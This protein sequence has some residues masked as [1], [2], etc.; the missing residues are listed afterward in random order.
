MTR[1]FVAILVEGRGLRCWALADGTRR[2]PPE[3]EPDAAFRAYGCY[4]R[5]FHAVLSGADLYM[6]VLSQCVRRR[7][8]QSQRVFVAS[9]F[10][11]ALSA[12]RTV[13]YANALV[14]DTRLSAYMTTG[15]AASV[16]ATA[17][18][19]ELFYSDIST[20]NCK[21]L[22]TAREILIRT[23]EISSLCLYLN[24]TLLFH[25]RHHLQIWSS[26]RDGRTVNC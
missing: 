16:V 20:R 8:A 22:Q 5:T 15:V 26:T 19:A 13:S 24:F 23:T 6:L 1:D 3:L 4:S 2:S 7:R 11:V 10:V 18:V 9:P 21:Y 14:L 17:D 12:A 25:I